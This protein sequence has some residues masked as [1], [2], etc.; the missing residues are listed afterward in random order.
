MHSP[1]TLTAIAI[2][3]ALAID[4]L[5]LV[6]SAVNALSMR[7]IKP[8]PDVVIANAVSI[9][10]PMRNE[11]INATAALE[12]AR[13]TTGCTDLQIVVL[14]DNSDDATAKLLQKFTNDQKI[15]VQ[16]GNTLPLGWLGKNYACHQLAATQ[17][18]RSSDYLVFLDADVRLHPHAIA[19]SITQMQQHNWDFLSPYPRQIAITVLEKLFQPLLQWSFISSLPLRLAE[20][21]R[22]SSMV[23]ANGQFFVVKRSAY[24]KSGGHHA[25]K[26][27]VLDDLELAR[28]LTRSGFHGVVAD[29]SAIVRCRMY[30]NKAEIFAGYRKSLWKA[31]GNPLSALC[32]GLFLVIGGVLPLIVAGCAT[33]HLWPLA[34]IAYGEVVVSRIITALR[35]RSEPLVSL[36]HSISML[37]FIYLLI[38]SWTGKANGQ[39]TWRGRK[40]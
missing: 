7:V 23:V 6:I 27:E 33:A 25:I 26:S 29:G 34:L 15:T 30:S 18:A 9:L 40:I 39:L 17:E 2:Y 32:L 4:S 31:F 16:N 5:A 19:S 38:T 28:L 36:L 20:K 35:T 3:C 12:S 37:L 13:A 10:I 1:S 24:E 14:D 22:F 8:N 21:L 11:E